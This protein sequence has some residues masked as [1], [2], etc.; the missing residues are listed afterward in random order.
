MT[1]VSRDHQRGGYVPSVPTYLSGQKPKIFHFQLFAGEEYLDMVGEKLKKWCK[2]IDTPSFLHNN[3][4]PP[5]YSSRI[6]SFFSILKRGL[7][8]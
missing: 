4:P 2:N 3:T 5:H 7:K 8:G 1:P 6:N